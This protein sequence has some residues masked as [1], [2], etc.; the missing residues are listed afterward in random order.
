MLLMITRAGPS[1][2]RTPWG[3]Q[4]GHYDDVNAG[5]AQ[6]PCK[7]GCP[8]FFELLPKARAARPDVPMATRATVAKGTAHATAGGP[9]AVI[10]RSQLSPH[11]SDRGRG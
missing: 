3:S 5:I 2:T 8:A 6:H 9:F 10:L 4:C 1:S 11:R 7:I